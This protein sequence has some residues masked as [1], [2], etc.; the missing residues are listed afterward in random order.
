MKQVSINYFF[1]KLS[2][3]K[4]LFGIIVLIP[5]FVTVIYLYFFSLDR[6]VSSAQVVVR[7]SDAP[8]SPMAPGLAI[9]TGGIDPASREYTLYLKEYIASYEMLLILDERINWTEHYAG[10]VTDPLYYLSSD[11]PIE[12]KLVFYNKM[13][14]A[15]YNDTTGLLSIEVQ[16]FSAD[17]AEKVVQEIIFE[18]KKF[19]NTVSREMLL[20]QAEFANQE[21]IASTDRY[22]KS[23]E[24]MINF[25]N[26]YKLLDVEATAQAR[27]ELI[28]ALESEVAKENARLTALVNTLSTK[29]PQVKALQNKI[30]S[31]E[32]QLKIEKARITSTS[33]D[34][35]LNSIASEYRQLQVNML[36]AEE[37]Y[38]SS[39]AV[40]ENAK[41]D[42]IKNVRNLITIV[43]P[44]VPEESTY[45][46]IFYNLLTMFIV[47]SL[48]YGI[49]CFVVASIKDHYE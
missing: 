38:K 47:L 3:P 4:V 11:A 33:I 32:E 42:A 31:L 17:F 9:L 18:S 23:K 25:Q 13:V 7:Q 10:H 46:R 8:S 26:Y 6:Y 20:E 36:V 12:E 34:D 27:L 15:H 49:V 45:P 35:P 29:A 1:K 48:V 28:S 21:L 19:I 39:L 5:F 40:V 41:M 2:R 14:I 43:P 30:S 24:E 44:I 37:F 22:Q 16:A